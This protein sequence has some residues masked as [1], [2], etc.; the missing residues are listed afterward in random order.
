VTGRVLVIVPTYNEAQNVERIVGRLRDSVP[1]AHALVVDDGSPDGTGEL[2]EKLA[3]RDPR[4]HVLRRAGKAGLGPAYV[5]GFAWAR[6]HGYDVVV[7]MDADGSHAPEQ[8]PRLL[9]ALDGADLV[10]GSRYVSGGSVEDWPVHRLLLSRLGNRYT[11]W[12]LRLPLTDATGGYRAARAEL[13]DRLPFD[14]VASQGYCFQV[15]WAWRAVRA[16]ARVAEVP[17]TF[18]ERAFGRSKMSGS[19][20]GEALVR[21]TVWGLRDRLADRLPGLV[22]RPVPGRPRDGGRS[23]AAR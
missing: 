4:V 5:A 18:T 15:D 6:A 10:L 16:G 17:I 11:R 8:L 19:I 9:A 12:L 1:E 23:S 2:A 7:E 13:I 20:V 22:S 21:V 3:A 14:D